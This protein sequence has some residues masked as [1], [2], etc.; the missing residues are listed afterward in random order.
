MKIGIVDDGMKVDCERKTLLFPRLLRR[1]RKG[2]G[3]ISVAT[4]LEFIL[5]PH[6]RTHCQRVCNPDHVPT[7][8]FPNSHFL[9]TIRWPIYF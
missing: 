7:S 5:L 1:L 9:L 8:A 2:V 4:S 3:L 6:P